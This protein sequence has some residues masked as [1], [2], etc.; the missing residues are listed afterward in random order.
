MGVIL[1]F[2]PDRTRVSRGYILFDVDLLPQGKTM[3]QH[4]K[5]LADGCVSLIGMAAAGKTTIGKVLSSI[6][7]WPAVDADNFIES[8]Y[9]APLQKITDVLSKDDFLDV[10]SQ[11][12]CGLRIKR[13]VISTGGS[14][15]YREAT[16]RHLASLGPIIY[17]DV[18]LPIILERI[19]RKPDR[20]LAIA[21]GQT[22]EDL[23]NERAKLYSQYA[24][25][26]VKAGERPPQ[27]YAGAIAD[28][29]REKYV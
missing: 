22:I 10:E 5:T 17:L 25:W 21:P 19:K 7:H 23:Y 28:W 11:A 3:S 15:V 16:M 9:G 27:E 12:I 1:L 4:E 18:S 14:V 29:L 6:L 13:C 24:T 26:T 20:G 8:I 2:R